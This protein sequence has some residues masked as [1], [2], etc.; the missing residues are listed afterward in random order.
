[1]PP[2]NHERIHPQLQTRRRANLRFLVLQMQRDRLE[3]WD[4]LGNLLG[5]IPGIDL[6]EMLRDRPITDAEAR[7]IEW[8]AQRPNGWLDRVR[9]GPLDT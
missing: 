6:Q 2:H 8:S 7:E 1:M 3:S 4:V 9:D 5:G